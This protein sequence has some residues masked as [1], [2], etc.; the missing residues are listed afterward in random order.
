MLLHHCCCLHRERRTLVEQYLTGTPMLFATQL[1]NLGMLPYLLEGV[2]NM[3]SPPADDPPGAALSLVV[4]V[5]LCVPLLGL[6]TLTTTE[7]MMR[8]NRGTGSTLV[9]DGCLAACVRRARGEESLAYWQR[10]LG[11]DSTFVLWVFY[12]LMVGSLVPLFPMWL[13]DMDNAQ[14]LC[15]VSMSCGAGLLTTAPLAAG[16]F[17]ML[18]ASYPENFGQSLIFGED[19]DPDMDGLE[20]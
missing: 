9:W 15:G 10:H 19:D 1:F 6:C 17:F 20:A 13:M 2:I 11:S 14:Q 18:R 5:L 12:V 4:G 3:M 7:E 8:R 16:A